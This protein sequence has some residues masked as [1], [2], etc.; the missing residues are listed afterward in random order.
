MAAVA[1]ASG[2]SPL[3]VV[4]YT[5]LRTLA[6]IEL[7]VTGAGGTHEVGHGQDPSVAPNGRMVSSSAFGSIGPALTVY[8]TAGRRSHSFFNDRVIATPLAWSP[9]SRYLAVLLETDAPRI[10]SA[11]LTVID[12]TT[13]T[14]G[15]SPPG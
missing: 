15:R 12:T 5:Q 7:Y 13:M 6:D 10:T 11:G 3:P 8:E 2:P 1:F 9:D 14:R 4:A